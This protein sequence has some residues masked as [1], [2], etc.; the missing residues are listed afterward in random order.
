MKF[1]RAEN[2][3]WFLYIFVGAVLIALCLAVVYLEPVTPS[4]AKGAARSSDVAALA[5]APW[6]IRVHPAGVTGGLKT[7]AKTR[8]SGQKAALRA[9]VRQTYD[10]MFLNPQKISEVIH[11]RFSPEAGFALMKSKA[12]FPK[13]ST[14][15]QTRVRRARLGIQASN[16][17]HA[18]GQVFIVATGITPSERIRIRHTATLW[19]R[20]VHTNWRVVAFEIDQERV[21]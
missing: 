1:L 9:L 18:A 8:L 13:Q 4:S 5:Q 6:R 7:R 14:N 20:R 11:T 21:R 10:A 17:R 2:R 12:G 19:L 16:A 15:I 3:E